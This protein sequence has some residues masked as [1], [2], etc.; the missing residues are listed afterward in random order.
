MVRSLP[1]AHRSGDMRCRLGEP[2]ADTTVH[3]QIL[4][5]FQVSY[6]GRALIDDNWAR[7]RAQSLIKLLALER[8]G[9]LHRDV[10]LEAL[11]HESDPGAAS[12]NLRQVT[13]QVRDRCSQ[14][15]APALVTLQGHLVCL[16]GPPRIDAHI[17]VQAAEAAHAEGSVA[18]YERALR[19]WTGP[20]LPADAYESWTEPHRER[21]L[22]LR[23]GLLLDLAACYVSTRQAALA[24]PLLRQAIEMEP[25]DEGPH[26]ALMRLYADAGRT[27]DALRQYDDL[28]RALADDLQVTPSS[29]TQALASV[30]KRE[31]EVAP[32]PVCPEISVVR[33]TDGVSLPF[34]AL[35]EGPAFV[36]LPRPPVS[37]IAM[38]WAIPEI[39]R[40][41]RRLAAGGRSLVR[42]DGRNTGGAS[43][44]AA[45]ITL[46][47]HAGDLLT[48]LDALGIE[49][50]TLYASMTAVPTAIF[51]A[52]RH[53]ERVRAL[54]LEHGHARGADI[55]SDPGTRIAEQAIK[56]DY[57]VYADMMARAEC[58]WQDEPCTTATRD[59]F[60]A[61]CTPADAQALLPVHA[62]IDVSDLL[63][64]VAAPTLV[65]HRR[66]TNTVSLRL[67]EALA[68]GITGAHLVILEGVASAPYLGDTDAVLRAIDDFLD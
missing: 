17:F 40:W 36:I 63:E 46:E 50:A 32:S 26:R 13:K 43:R 55:F 67:S 57:F 51:V 15:N 7:R 19:L 28:A 53:P 3:I 59:M 18:G 30:I 60:N 16:Q 49:R 38:E 31:R 22:A 6:G 29:E 65:L 64:R 61:A 20:P 10:V 48:V 66:E 68:A 54:V 62:A 12:A 27:G 41:Y 2:P 58:G 39:R 5:P 34:W 4:G 44:G 1:A 56:N 8:T 52:A 14:A 11:W 35:G 9:A 42:Y 25:F 37:H 23:R 45:N 21:L 33:S 24:E 47:D